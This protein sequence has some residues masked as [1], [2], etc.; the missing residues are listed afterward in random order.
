[1]NALPSR[2][3]WKTEYAEIHLSELPQW[4]T[5]S[6][7]AIAHAE[8]CLFHVVCAKDAFGEGGRERCGLSGRCCRR[9]ARIRLQTRGRPHE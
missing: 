2:T 9:G 3:D 1:M 7:H 4:N 5:S 6:P 8:S